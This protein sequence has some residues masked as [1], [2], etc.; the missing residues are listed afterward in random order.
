MVGETNWSKGGLF[1]EELL[2]ATLIIN[3]SMNLESICSPNT[4]IK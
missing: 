4:V 3:S 1:L 2:R